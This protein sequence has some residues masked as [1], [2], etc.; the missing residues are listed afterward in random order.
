MEEL[1]FSAL[2]PR[3]GTRPIL[4][5][6]SSIGNSS[7][8][9]GALNW[10]S[11]WSGL[12]SFG[13]SVKNY[14][15]KA[16]NSSA[17]QALRQRL[18]DTKFQDKIV[19]GISSGLH[20]ALD[21]TRQELDKAIKKRLEEDSISKESFL[22]EKP[23]A[24]LEPIANLPSKRKRVR[25]PVDT[26]PSYEEVV[27]KELPR[28]DESEKPL[29]LSANPPVPIISKRPVENLPFLSYQSSANWQNTLNDIVGLGLHTV[30][31]RRCF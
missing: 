4:S 21:I 29:P 19:E 16:W 27:G 15:S 17:G 12:K 14:G 24:V 30:K 22:E 7:L 3:R 9:G 10:G 13:S 11:I 28:R 2:A 31:K 1:N 25:D 18:K 5:E 8:N 20:G 26:P 6:S 23:P